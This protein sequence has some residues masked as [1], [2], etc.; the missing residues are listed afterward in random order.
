[1]LLSLQQDLRQPLLETPALLHRHSPHPLG[2]ERLSPSPCLLGP[3]PRSPLPAREAD[4][5]A[6]TPPVTGRSLPPLPVAPLSRLCLRAPFFL[7]LS[8]RT[9]QPPAPPPLLQATGLPPPRMWASAPK[10]AARAEP[11]R[12]WVPTGAW[13]P[14]QPAQKG[15]AVGGEGRARREGRASTAPNPPAPARCQLSEPLYTIRFPSGAFS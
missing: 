8:S 12:S 13:G 15:R 6:R 1:M 4:T 11:W 2:G 5:S 3:P 9:R 10:D 14:S 7:L